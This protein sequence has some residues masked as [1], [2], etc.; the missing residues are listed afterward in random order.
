ME[1]VT[2]ALNELAHYAESTARTMPV[3]GVVPRTVAEDQ[4][5]YALR[6]LRAA[7]RR[8]ESSADASD[9]GA[10]WLLDNLWLCEREGNA[11]LAAFHAAGRL[12][13]TCEGALVPALCRVLLASG[14]GRADEERIAV[15]LEGFQR[16]TALTGRELGLLGASLRAAALVRLAQLYRGEAPDGGAAALHFTTLRHI[17]SLDLDAV[18]EEADAVERI[19][20]R[21]PAGVYSLMDERSRRDYRARVETLSRRKNRSEMRVAEEALRLAERAEGVR[22]RHIGYWLYENPLG[23]GVPRKTGAAYILANVLFTFAL[24][25][26]LALWA[27]SVLAAVLSL[28]PVSEIVKSLL[29]RALLR[30]VPPRHVPRL[31]LRKG[32]PPE[33]KTVCVLSILLTGEKAADIALRRLEEFRAA[34]RAC[35]ENLLFGLL[36]DLPESGETLSHTDRTLLDAT[37]AKTEALNARCGGGFFLFT[38]D[39]LY[40]RD[41][42]SFAP[43]ERKR[44]ATLELCRLLAGEETG[45][46]VRAGDAAEL[47]GTRYILTLDADTRLEPESARALIGAALHPLNRPAVDPKKG[48]V[49]RG[50]GVLHPRIAVSLESAYRNDFTRLFAPAGGGDPYGSDT[51]EVYM[52]AFQSGGFAGKGLIHVGAYLACLGE[53]IPEGRVLSH[54]A[55]EGAF[56][57]GGYV[58]DVELTDGFPSGAMS[59]FAR[60]NRWRRGDVQNLPWLFR[61]GKAL[62]PIER[63]R[64]FDSFRRAL[65]PAGLFIS[66]GAWFLAPSAATRTAA[67]CA[68]LVLLLPVLRYC[69]GVLFRDGREVRYKSAALHG[70]GGE[71]TRAFTQLLFLAAEAWTSVSAIV[72]ALWRM[73]VSH[74]RLLQW[75]TAEQSER[76]AVGLAGTFAALWPVVYFSGL[77][78]AFSQ[79]FAGRA[80]AVCWIF[81]PLFAHRLGREKKEKPL[82]SGERE[83]LLRRAAEIWRYFRENCT[84]ASHYLP[85]DNVQL[86]PP[87][88]GADRTSPTNIAIAL[89]GALS[90]LELGI[91]SEEE[92]LTLCENILD[93]IERLSK[94]QGHLYNWY[95]TKTLAPLDPAYISTVDSGN[96]AAALVSCAAGLDAHGA[97][98]LAERARAIAA[99]MDFRALYDEKR[100]LFR[101]GL[102][103]GESAPAQSWYDLLESEERLT[104]YFAIASGQIEPRHWQQLSRAQVGCQGRRGMVSWSGSLFEYLMPELFLPLYRGSHLWESARF[105]VYV[106]RRRT[107]GEKKLWGVSES[108]FYAFDATDHY[109]YKAHGSARLALCRGGNGESVVSP[110]SSY[111]ALCAAPHAAVE[112]LRRMED[113]GLSGPYGL[114]EA[115]DFTSSRTGGGAVCV[116]CVMAH[117]LGMSLCAIANALC[118]GVLRRWFL[119]DSAMAAY[120]G[121]LQEKIPLGGKLLHRAPGGEERG[122]RVGYGIP[123]TGEGAD[124]F[125]PDGAALSNGAY[126]L[127]ITA[128]GLSRASCGT[129]IPYRS[130]RMPWEDAPGAA[131]WVETNGVRRSLLPKPWEKSALRWRFTAGEACLAGQSEGLLWEMCC[132]VS[133]TYPGELRRLTLRSESAAPEKVIFGFEPVLL[134]ARDYA[135]HPAFARLGLCTF[136]KDGVLIVYRAPRGSQSAQY[137]ALACAPEADFSSDFR[138]FPA[139]G[140]AGKFRENTGWQNEPYIAAR[141]SL[142]EG[143]T[144]ETAFAL[145]VAGDADTAAHGAREILKETSG[146]AMANAAAS[147]WGMES[148]E[149]AAA[150][151]YLRALTFPQLCAEGRALPGGTRDVLWR[152]GIS[153]DL[154]VMVFDGGENGTEAALRELRRHALLGACGVEYDLVFLTAPAGDYRNEQ[155]A[156]IETA[157]ETM[158]LSE[159]LSLPGGVYFASRGEREALLACA[160]LF[161]DAAGT[162][163]PSGRA[164]TLRLPPAAEEETG[165]PVVSYSTEQ[166]VRFLSPPMPPRAWANML[167]GGGLGC[168]AADSGPA[169]LWYENARECPIVP[170]P[171]DALAADGAERLWIETENGAESLFSDGGACAV[172]FGFGYARW[173]R[174]IGGNRVSATAFIAPDVPVRVLL[175]ESTAPCE[176]VYF[177]PVQLAPEREDAASVSVRRDGGA[178]RAENPRCPYEDVRV[179]LRCSAPWASTGTDARFLCGETSDA[180]RRGIP[181]LAGIFRL[182]KEAVLLLGTADAPALLD[183]AR[184]REALV[185]TKAWWAQR[186]MGEKYSA[187]MLESVRRLAPWSIYAALCCRV[188]GRGSLYQSGGAIGFRDQLQDRINL[189][190]IDPAGARAH[191]L[192]CC[193]HQYAEGDVQHWYHPGGGKTDK[194]VRTDCADD[195]LWLPWAVCEY[196]RVTGDEALCTE[197]APYLV[198]PPLAR[199]E[200]SR[201]ETPALSE[202]RGTVLDHCH[203]A[204]ALVLRRGVGAHRLLLMG[205]GDWND[206]FDAMGEGAESVWL[207][208]FA[209]G[210]FHGF[211]ALLTRLGEPGADR[212]ET[213]AA[214]LGA[215]ANEAWEGDHYLRGYY[216]DG[217]PLGASGA[218]ACRI[219]S[220]AQSFAAFSPYA[221]GERVQTALTAALDAL[222]NREKRL[223]RIYAPPFLPEQRAPGYVSTYGPGFRENGGQ[224]TH[225]A[226]W[227]ALAL[228]RAGRREEAERIAEDIAL[229][230][231]APEYG[232]EPFVLP[233]DI[234]YAPGKEGRAGW[235]WYTGAAGW[236]YRLLRGLYGAQP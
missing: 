47:R 235:S 105:A 123:R 148:G 164:R 64:L 108:A 165:M 5:R 78:L 178:L 101:I 40:S 66:F 236:Y 61:R 33:G 26:A 221:D 171:G 83:F 128:N 197:S 32:V 41:S 193:A 115:I 51:G 187:A 182:E 15:F 200:H 88:P 79:T 2:I 227:L 60:A 125:S 18:L 102:L 110:Y 13:T 10:R 134:G 119:S 27:R 184:A 209:S 114:W 85:P 107:F 196:V 36:C 194:G 189:L 90:A 25:A 195:L 144:C 130:A 231:T 29:D 174:D 225:A 185:R 49:F 205:G 74:R 54:D 56:L 191:I 104:A 210:V 201:Y 99:A 11:A 116:R 135:A 70:L 133:R 132:T 232:A 34:S 137:L 109:R 220:V 1:T 162:S 229:S 179:T 219:D 183:I 233:A 55:L 161:G 86:S 42:G 142:P 20:R 163:L 212:Y 6:A 143:K 69:L 206:G 46:H 37:A 38:R 103:P 138:Q 112:N 80:A 52:D 198:S 157:L 156:A 48:I 9:G 141:V 106:Q 136:V 57:R 204:A 44:G 122:T 140:G 218:A 175:I 67:L 131:L 202:E 124:P 166:E 228:L 8:M 16:K 96:L 98:S 100:R 120:T 151:E 216:S 21:D 59:Y 150:M 87:A 63:W 222:W 234:A 30:A 207:T 62:R 167:Y 169:A 4:I 45:L 170:W 208:W 152:L 121:L 203:R 153:G 22:R 186:V 230:L 111:L 159:T 146:F 93:T 72:L 35:G 126:R 94:W 81:T 71:L 7:R 17:A 217:A 211:S 181:A 145:C 23:A 160:A 19:L 95:D 91:A 127:L 31:A 155:R 154:P 92:A 129:L 215:A 199:G 172:T 213:A 214:A 77:L 158:R 168:I 139:R 14:G 58:S 75:Q 39:R 84:A 149:S 53:R 180:L 177:A 68:L 226:V 12:R 117:H 224:Y 28:L 43:W 65:L 73:G 147:V 97:P 24:S 173:E 190:P 50:H 188:L 113:T 223:V 76:R 176:I 192:A 82:D 118:G 89:A 3:T